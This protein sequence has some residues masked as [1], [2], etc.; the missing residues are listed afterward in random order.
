MPAQAGIQG[1]AA[2]FAVLGPG[3]RRGDIR[4][5]STPSISP[6]EKIRWRA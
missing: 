5:Q 3:L 6:V 1:L 4:L 2:F